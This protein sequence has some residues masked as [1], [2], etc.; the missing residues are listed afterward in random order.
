MAWTKRILDPL[1]IE[2]EIFGII[3]CSFE[4]P[5]VHLYRSSGTFLK[6][7]PHHRASWITKCGRMRWLA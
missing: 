6:A 1:Y 2:A 3:N 4:A 5:M 7:H